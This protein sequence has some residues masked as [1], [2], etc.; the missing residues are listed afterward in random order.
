MSSPYLCTNLN[1]NHNSRRDISKILLIYVVVLV[2][3]FKINDISGG[4]VSHDNSDYCHIMNKFAPLL[5]NNWNKNKYIKY[6]D[7]CKHNSFRNSHYVTILQ[8]HLFQEVF[9]FIILQDKKY[10]TQFSMQVISQ[11]YF[12]AQL[13]AFNIHVGG[14]Q[15]GSREPIQHEQPVCMA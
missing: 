8:E 7:I 6:L 14:C 11:S 4:Y 15:T 3:S 2:S 12:N 9:H 1:V 5:R 13:R 10:T